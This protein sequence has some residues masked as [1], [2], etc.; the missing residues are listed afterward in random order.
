MNDA[1]NE[2]LALA[3][4]VGIEVRHARLGG[5]GGGLAIVRGRRVLF[6]DL[7]ASAADQ[8][9]RS[10]RALAS[11]DDFEGLFVRPDVRAL[12]DAHRPRGR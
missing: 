1:F 2:L 6:I 9:E 5:E 10:A 3:Q 12:L 7:D 11:L 8:L 4:R